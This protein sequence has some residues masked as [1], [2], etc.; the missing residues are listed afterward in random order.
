MNT[1][2]DPYL[3]W[4]DEISLGEIA[5][6][7]GKNASLGQM[8]GRMRPL[9]IQV[10]HGF[11]TTA[12]A[13]RAFLEAND[14]P[15]GMHAQL[16]QL[17]EDLGNLS[18]VG[19]AIRGMLRGAILPPDFAEA[20][21]RAY[22]KLS[23][24]A[25]AEAPGVAVRSS[26]TAEDLPE[27]SFAGQQ[28]S[29]LNVVGLPA[30][31]RA[32]QDCF[33]SLFTDRAIAYR[34]RHGF[35]DMDVALS[36]GVQLMV[37]SDLACAGVMF[38][39]DCE[40][41]F[42]DAVLIEGTWGLGESL[43]KGSVTG[44][45]WRLFKPMLDDHTFH[46]V[47]SRTLGS[48]TQ[49][50][51]YGSDGGTQAID[52][53]EKQRGQW[54][55]EEH[56]VI[57]LARQACLIEVEYGRPMDIEW[58]KDGLTGEFY[59]VQARPETVQSQRRGTSMKVYRMQEKSRPL[60]TGQAIG[61]AVAVGP[62]TLIHSVSQS[63]LF[64]PGDIL[65]TDQTDPDWV[66]LMRR[67][68]GI[69]TDRGGRT[70]HAAIVCRELGLP[71]VVG[72]GSATRQVPDGAEVTIDCTQGD[73]GYVYRGS[74]AHS[75][76]E[77]D[78]SDAPATQTKVM[79]NIASPEAAFRWWNLPVDGIGLARMEFIIN[80]T[81]RVHPMA[82][83]HYDEVES[84]E[85]RY[86][87]DRATEAYESRESYFVE[88]LAMG[89]AS[90]AASRYPQPVIVRLSDFKT[91]E[92]ANLIGGRQFEPSESNPMLGWRG[93]SR[94][95]SEGYREGFAL[96]CR[97]LLMARKRMGLNNIIAMVPFCRTPEEGQRVLEE[98]EHHGLRRGDGGF[99]VYV[100]AEIP[101]NIVL[102]DEFAELFDGFS[103]GSN[104]LTQLTLG[105]DR[106]SEELT[107]LF[108]D[109]HAA[110]R[111]S[112][113]QLIDTAHEHGVPVGLCGQAPSDHPEF[114]RFLVEAGI[115]SISVNPDSVLAVREAV[116]QAEAER[117]V[118]V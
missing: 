51:V 82:L 53:D 8:Y 112:I 69:V 38:T 24:E 83:I 106:D 6:V 10:P 46:P 117:K 102:A 78:W 72:A 73:A 116:A 87:I 30:V 108:D 17:D 79:L 35:R 22:T 91:N 94:Y 59:I 66:P 12:S 100:M 54:C 113:R 42:P 61:T 29:F 107:Y 115:D 71:A 80:D 118:T 84:V 14:L 55:L 86:L 56:E 63:D 26:A 44:D 70:S 75:V 50:L 25:Q 111:R 18:Q 28:E 64:K 76:E 19:E 81:I 31:L 74:V 105:I 65:V 97:A 98:L 104:D 88:K 77:Q 43:V 4:F 99:Q 89:I 36:A 62:V 110:V 37:R 60:V 7:G 114:A 15:D 67:A 9:G 40:T 92:Y 47:I 68:A 23:S 3:R 52:N 27:A 41:G 39:L 49:R 21:G 58:A 34:H 2:A 109:R 11:A 48:K 20:I 85:A 103:I 13:Y 95:Y 93:A 5:A 1:K 32:I 45:Q 33:V 16:D 101:S 96:E 57:T 90:I